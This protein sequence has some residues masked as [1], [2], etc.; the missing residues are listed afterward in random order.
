MM[1]ASKAK[2]IVINSGH[3]REVE[4]AARRRLRVWASAIEVAIVDCGITPPGTHVRAVLDGMRSKAWERV[5]LALSLSTAKEIPGVSLYLFGTMLKAPNCWVYEVTQTDF[6]S[7]VRAWL[8][9]EGLTV[10]APRLAAQFQLSLL[11]N[12]TRGGL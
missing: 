6:L 8:R 4:Q 7:R 1:T 9:R 11:T 3:S 10:D 5:Y 12:P 2:L